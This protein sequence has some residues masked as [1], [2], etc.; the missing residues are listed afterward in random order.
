MTCHFFVL[1]RLIDNKLIMILKTLSRDKF[2]A[3]NVYIESAQIR[4]SLSLFYI[5][6]YTE[7]R[8]VHPFP[9]ND[10]T[11]LNLMEN[12]QLSITLAC[13]TTLLVLESYDH[14]DNFWSLLILTPAGFVLTSRNV[15][16]ITL[17]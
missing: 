10:S 4:E 6:C 5:S 8:K 3:F 16:F 9:Y 7:Q 1:R 15:N 17:S 14:V 12:L 13:T 2:I 11:H